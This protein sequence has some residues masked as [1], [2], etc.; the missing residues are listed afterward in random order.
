MNVARE[1]TQAVFAERE[2]LAQLVLRDSSRVSVTRAAAVSG[3]VVRAACEGARRRAFVRH[4]RAGG[5]GRPRGILRDDVFA[6]LD[7]Q[8]ERV[9]LHLTPANAEATVTLPPEA[10]GNVVAVEPSAAAERRRYLLDTAPRTPAA[11]AAAS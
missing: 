1:A 11:V 8:F 10:A 6:A 9:A 3:A 5:K 4:V 7:V 2:A